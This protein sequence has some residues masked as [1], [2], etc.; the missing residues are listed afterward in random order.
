MGVQVNAVDRF[1]TLR[2]SKIGMAQKNCYFKRVS[3]CFFQVLGVGPLMID[4][5]MQDREVSA[6][7]VYFL[8]SK[9]GFKLVFSPVNDEVSQFFFDFLTVFNELVDGRLQLRYQHQATSL[10]VARLEEFVSVHGGRFV[11]LR[12]LFSA[13]SKLPENE[14]FLMMLS[15][16]D[17]TEGKYF[18]ETYLHFLNNSEDDSFDEDG[19]RKALSLPTDLVGD[20]LDYYHIHTVDGSKKSLIGNKSKD[21]RVCRFCNRSYEKGGAKFTKVAHAIS[22]ALGNNNIILADECDECNEYFG[23]EIEPHLITYLDIY[24]VFAGVKGY[25]GAPQSSFKNGNA[26]WKDGQVVIA[27]HNVEGDAETGFRISVES[28][29][30]IVLLN[31]YKALCKFSLSTIHEKYVSCFPDAF[32]WVRGN[33]VSGDLRLPFVAIRFSNKMAKHPSITN[34]IRLKEDGG[35]PGLISELVIGWYMFVTIIPF[36]GG[37]KDFSIE[38]DYEEL[39]KKFPH[40]SAMGGWV[41]QRFDRADETPM[42]YV[43]NLLPSDPSKAKA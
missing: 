7:G 37:A 30:A 39:W 33:Y 13:I 42:R 23:S 14:F 1:Y 24:R 25:K 26:F 11:H 16:P 6:L 2:Y 32:S 38:S 22:K 31:L 28:Q 4:A 18:C 5:S 41:F 10:L 20:L 40:Y 9:T 17:T 29:K 21:E 34:Y 12:K 8:T 43:V 15:E 36:S 35:V 3:Q 19:F 27:S